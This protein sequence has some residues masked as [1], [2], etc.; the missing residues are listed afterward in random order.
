MR[1]KNSQRVG[2]IADLWFEARDDGR[3]RKG[4]SKILQRDMG[5]ERGIVNDLTFSSVSSFLGASLNMRSQP[6]QYG[7][8]AIRRSVLHKYLHST[9]CSSQSC[10]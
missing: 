3:L 10:A 8:A 9:D 7:R 5:A 6:E 1:A 4:V 2:K